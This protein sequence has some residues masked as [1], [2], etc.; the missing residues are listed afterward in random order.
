MKECKTTDGKI[1]SK[2]RS[3]LVRK[4]LGYDSTETVSEYVSNEEGEIKLTKKKVTVKSVAP[5]MT[6]IKLLMDEQSPLE[7]MTDEQLEQEKSRLLELLQKS[8]TKKKE[9]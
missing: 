4:A 6:A 7:Q 2:L 9:K 5:D 8:E 3:A 1:R